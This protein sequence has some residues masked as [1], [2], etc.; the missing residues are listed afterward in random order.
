MVARRQDTRY[1]ASLD[2]CLNVMSM[3]LA[4]S[5]TLHGS[6]WN[7]VIDNIIFRRGQRDMTNV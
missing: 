2:K 1:R 5:K 4:F 7:V 6:E 3:T